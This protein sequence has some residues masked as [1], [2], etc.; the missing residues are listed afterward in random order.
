MRPPRSGDLASI[1]RIVIH[2]AIGIARVG[3][4]PDE[5]FLGPE[6]PGPHPVPPGG[7]K[8]GAGRIKRQA[9][10]F[11]LYGL[12]RDGQV[13]AEVTAADADI[14]WTRPSRQHQSRL[15]QLRHCARHPPGQGSPA[16]ALAS[17]ARSHP[18]TAPQRS[19]HRT[20]QIAD[21][22]RA[23]RRSAGRTRMPTVKIATARFDGGTFLGAEVPL[24]ELRTD[25]DGRLLVF[26][27]MGHSAPAI[28]GAIAV[29]F[30]NNDLWYDDTSDGPVDATVRIDG[31]EI[32]VTGAWVV[33]APPNYAPGIQSVVTMYDV[34]FE[35][36]TSAR[37][38]AAAGATLVHPHDLPALRA[39]GAE[40]V[41]QCRLP[42]RFRLGIASDF[43]APD[44]LRCWPAPP[45]GR[46]SC[47]DRSSSGFAIPSYTSMEYGDLPPY[48]GDDVDLPADNP[49]QW[50]AVLPI[51][52]DWLRQWADGDFDADWPDGGLTFPGT[53][54]G[55]CRSPSSRMHSTAPCWMNA[56]AVLSTPAAR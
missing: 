42:A 2:P 54:R 33:V 25:D 41:G 36:A 40:P 9:A 50:M 13:V 10:R 55:L 51:Q 39:D 43:L 22:S 30:A 44:A 19:D 11:R 4:S 31:R 38:G 45:R 20:R 1:E 27:G 8:D 56:S 29:T 28:P 24:G 37:A 26:G 46:R 18:L 48:Y 3:N 49:R 14:R 15:V 52:Y 34:I 21:R 35:V 17:R 7:F 16:R 6:T 32:P 47:A 53:T 23:A 5:W 12:D